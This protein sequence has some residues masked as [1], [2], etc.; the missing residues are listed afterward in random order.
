MAFDPKNAIVVDPNRNQRPTPTQ[1][2]GFNPANVRQDGT[3]VRVEGPSRK[4]VFGYQEPYGSPNASGGEIFKRVIEEAIAPPMHFANQWAMNYPRSIAHGMGY[5]MPGEDPKTAV[6]EVVSRTAGLGGAVT[7]PAPVRALKALSAST[8][9]LPRVGTGAAF[10][11]IAAPDTEP[12]VKALSEGGLTVQSLVEGLKQEFGQRTGAAA[13]GAAAGPMVGKVLDMAGPPVKRLASG[14]AGAA[15]TKVADIIEA[16]KNVIGAPGKAVDSSLEAVAGLPKGTVAEMKAVRP[17]D[18]EARQNPEFQ[19]V[20]IAAPAQQRV[21]PGIQN[22]DAETLRA[23]GLEDEFAGRLGQMDA[24]RLSQAR[25]QG[26]GDVNEQVKKLFEGKKGAVGKQYEEAMAE[27]QKSSNLSRFRKELRE[28]LADFV[29]RKNKGEFRGK[30]PD[31]IKA[32]YQPFMELFK[33]YRQGFVGPRDLRVLNAALGD[34][35][36]KNRGSQVGAK[37]QGLRVNLREDLAADTGSDKLKQAVEQ[38]KLMK[39]FEDLMKEDFEKFLMKNLSQE[40]ISELQDLEKFVGKEFIESSRD[41]IAARRAESFSKSLTPE[42][43]QDKIMQQVKRAANPNLAGHNQA[44]K[45][46]E[47]LLGKEAAAKV[48]REQ[49]GVMLAQKTNPNTIQPSVFSIVRREARKMVRAPYKKAEP[50]KT[51]QNG[52]LKILKTNRVSNNRGSVRIGS[53]DAP[54]VKFGGETDKVA[55]QRLELSRLAR[56]PGGG[57]RTVYKNNA[58]VVK[59]ARSPL[60][61]RANDL[62]GDGFIGD[63]LPEL[64]ERGKDYIVVEYI[65]RNDA[66]TRKFLSVLQKFNPSDFDKKTKELQEALTKLGLEDF[67]NYDLLWNDFKAPRNWG[68]KDGKAFLLDEGALQKD[69]HHGYKPNEF[70]SKDWRQILD[71]R[72]QKPKAESNA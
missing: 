17:F 48:I 55:N 25:F 66:E 72:R 24:P 6:G 68:W 4:S 30:V 13:M 21:Q 23:L 49:K 44:V 62:A 45:M 71:L 16:L 52:F 64:I 18:I 34:L 19:Q 3:A 9:F 20:N 28:V 47:Q 14:A 38:Y 39:Q 32:T 12:M 11:G 58:V 27:I 35:V 65:P 8:K 31:D 41:I 51:A 53:G 29:R 67:M 15:G 36:E 60:G 22:M 7:G 69:L 33:N 1:D 57:N 50:S 70:D 46:L 54:E 63:H 59:V 42:M 26:L 5:E 40:Q 56:L 2:G 61:L 37:A 10:S 43:I